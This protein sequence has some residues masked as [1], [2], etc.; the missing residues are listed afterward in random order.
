MSLSESP[1]WQALA[2]HHREIG[3]RHLR[4]LFAE[5]AGR[6]EALDLPGRR[7]LPRLLEEPA[8]GRDDP[9]ARRA[10]RAG[11]APR[12]HRGDVRRRAHQHHR[13]PRR[14]ARRA[15]RP[16]DV[17]P[18]GGRPG[19]AAR[20][21]RGARPDGRVRE[22]GPRRRVDRRHRRADPRRREHR[23]RRLRPRPGD[24]LPRPAR[25]LR[26]RADLPVRLEH[27]PDRPRR[28]HPRPGPRD[29]A[30]HR[31]VEDLHHPGDADQRPRG[32]PLAGRGAGR[33][34][35]GGREALRRRLHERG[36]GGRVRHRHRE[37]VRVLGLGGRPL[38][39]HLGHRP[40][41]HGRHRS[42]AV[43]GDARRL[44]QRW[45]STSARRRTSRTCRRCWA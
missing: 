40:V 25:L 12:A 8:H 5:D 35:R 16:P 18:R 2:A 17:G 29:D 31:R 24:G 26:P 19:R 6:G 14:P 45:T 13:G 7:P 43:P 27:R 41:A 9:A 44:P 37:H 36:E 11:G 4:D 3:D 42:R 38:L 10:R 1:E 20:R 15:A 32:A 33:G 23:H 34:R 21:A 30:V 39:L 22:P 28:G